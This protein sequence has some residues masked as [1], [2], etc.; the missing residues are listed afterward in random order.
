MITRVI[1]YSFSNNIALM[2]Y[3][4]F[5]DWADTVLRCRVWCSMPFALMTWF[6]WISLHCTKCI[7]SSNEVISEGKLRFFSMFY[8]EHFWYTEPY[9]NY[10]LMFLFSFHFLFSC[11]MHIGSTS[12]LVDGS[13]RVPWTSGS[14]DGLKPN[15]H[16]V[17]KSLSSYLFIL[18]LGRCS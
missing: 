16:L 17:G 11:V 12:A 7:H 5:W 1:V 6:I 15:L 14:L 4:L 3:L 18:Q 2:W 13:H 10:F 9:I 8:L